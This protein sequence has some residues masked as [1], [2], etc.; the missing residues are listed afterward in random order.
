MQSWLFDITGRISALLAVLDEADDKSIEPDIKNALTGIYKSDIPA[1]VQDGIEYIKEQEKLIAAVDERIKEMTA[2]KK[3]LENRMKRVKKGYTDFLLAVE[4]EK[5]ETPSGRMTV[6]APTYQTII[7]SIE[8]LPDAY[9]RT[10][11]KIEADKA[12]IK[13]AIQGGHNVKG[14]HLEEKQSIRIK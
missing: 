3:S 1:A 12:S 8:D 13:Q 10:T 5:V 11:V 2:Y 9:K 7:D 6:A 14:A 4:R